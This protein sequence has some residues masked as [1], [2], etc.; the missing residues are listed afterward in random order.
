MPSETNA[1]E[2]ARWG[3]ARGAKRSGGPSCSQCSG[4]CVHV[5]LGDIAGSLRKERDRIPKELLAVFKVSF[6]K[7]LP[8]QV[9]VGVKAWKCPDGKFCNLW[10]LFVSRTQRTGWQ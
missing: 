7:S 10:L 1:K 5:Q 8:A 6:V 9:V 2:A 3:R 4:Q